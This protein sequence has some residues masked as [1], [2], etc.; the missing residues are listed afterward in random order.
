MTDPLRLSSGSTLLNLAC[1][2]NPDHAMLTGKYYWMAGSSSS[3]KTFFTLTFMAEASI[4]PAFDGY[5]LI[6]DNVEDGAMMDFERFFGPK[7]AARVQPPKPGPVFSRYVA[8]FYHNLDD[9]IAAAKKKSGRPFIYLLDSMDSLDAE[10]TTKKFRAAGK[11]KSDTAEKS[12]GDYGMEKAKMNSERLRAVCSDLRDTNSILIILSQVRENIG[13]GIFEPDEITA[14][15]R[16]LKFYATW[17]LWSSVA[18]TVTKLINGQDRQI[19]IVSRVKVK[20][21]RLSGKEWAVEI[22]LYWSH[23]LDDVGGCVDFLIKEKHW[24][25]DDN[26]V[27][28]AKDLGLECRRGELID[29]IEHDKLYNDLKET[30]VSVWSDIEAQSAVHRHNKYAA[31]GG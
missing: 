3:G 23:G 21:N 4:N 25:K 12:A 1:S 8:D 29:K 19:G 2:G 15:G 6:Y 16:A 10:T 26:G 13:G 9:R 20:K 11:K 5:D 31:H 18:R 30:V 22:P 17:Q 27:V 7:A 28:F 14:G 24:K